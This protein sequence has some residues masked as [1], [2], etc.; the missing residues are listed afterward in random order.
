[1]ADYFR[2]WLEMGR[3][4]GAVLP[5]IFFV[6]WF[7]KDLDDGRFLWPGFGENARVLEWA[8]RRC[9]GAAEAAETP[10]GRVPTP[11]ALDTD[12]L[13]I[14]TDDLDALL[15]VDPAEWL[16]EVDP[17]REFYAKFGERLPGEL[18]AQLDALEQ[19]LRET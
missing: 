7:R 16:P 13:A 8:F 4:E 15:K 14:G 11:G 12:G 10:I 3:R 17:I 6:N 2:H 19:R 5:K 18:L 1:M 9:D